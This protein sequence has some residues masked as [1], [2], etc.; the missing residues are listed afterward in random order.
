MTDPDPDQRPQR[1]RDVVALLAKSRPARAELRRAARP[2]P[3]R[4]RWPSRR[5]GCSPTSS[6]PLG[7]LLRLGVLGFG[8]GG[9]LGMVGVRLGLTI[10]ITVLAIIAFPA[11]KKIRRVGKRARRDARRGPGR[12]HRHHA[13]RDGTPLSGTRRR[14]QLAARARATGAARSVSTA[15]SAWVPSPARRVT[16]EKPT[17]GVT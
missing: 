17:P 11:R 6:E 15:T 1:A 14:G 13:R 16:P 2:R 5:A 7:T 4:R 3:D 9:W 10:T 12:L 8:A